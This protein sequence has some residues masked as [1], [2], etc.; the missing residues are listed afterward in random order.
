MIDV[1]AWR[2]EERQRLYAARKAMTAEQRREAARKIADVLDDHCA[3]H[4]P[5]LV[6][7]YWPIKYEL[8]LLS[9]ARAR[10]LASRFCLPVVVA[11]GQ[12]LEYWLWTPGDLMQSGV[13]DIQ[14]P[15]HRDVVTPDLMIAPLLGFDRDR[16]RLGN[17]GGYFDRTLAA[18]ADR[19]FV[20]GV[21]YASSEL[22]TIHPQPH[23]I[24]MD[25]IL[26]ERS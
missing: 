6:G 20:I 16:Y 21:G 25:L 11:R 13:W 9:W 5:A 8:N 18:R 3:C 23:D 10:A 2:Q 12:P 22:E 19:P 15:A 4:K 7:L 17:G 14:V 26:T 1:T 24:P